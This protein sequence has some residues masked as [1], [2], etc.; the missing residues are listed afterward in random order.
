[1]AFFV[2]GLDADGPKDEVGE[3]GDETDP[4]PRID[5]AISSSEAGTVSGSAMGSAEGSAGG[6]SSGSSGT[7]Y[8]S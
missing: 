4:D 5:C 7:R 8:I 3:R 6:R 1:M 2:G